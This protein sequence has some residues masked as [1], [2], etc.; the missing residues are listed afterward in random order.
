MRSLEIIPVIDLR[1]GTVVHARLGLRSHYRPLQS[2]LCR[3][4][5]PEAV[6]AGLLSLHPFTT[7]YVADLDAIERTGSNESAIGDL[8]RA[9]PN[10]RFWVDA[11]LGE[12]GRFLDWVSR[13]L[14]DPV[15]GSEAQADPATLDSLLGGPMA[16]SIILSLD[17]AGEDFRGPRELLEP[18]RWPG[19]VIVMTL[20]RVGS[21]LG[22]DLKRL[23]PIIER[24]E[25]RQVFA[26]GGV[27][28]R[29]DLAELAQAGAAGVLVAS[30]L[31]DGRIGESVLRGFG[32]AP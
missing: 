25:G 31:H 20:A 24:S 28:D 4:S 22:P 11:G 26:A 30:A 2:I 21:G 18:A 9:F 12:P 32:H 7:L 5:A 8:R 29:S 3:G 23:A 19:R 10:L 1:R 17:F 6:V 27:R 13:D 15:L 16:Q 14:G